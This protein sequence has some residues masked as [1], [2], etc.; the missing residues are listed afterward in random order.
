MCRGAVAVAVAVACLRLRPGRP[1]SSVASLLAGAL[2]TW[3]RLRP[4]ISPF[5]FAG[6]AALDQAQLPRRSPR[7]PC[8]DLERST[9]SPRWT[10]HAASPRA[11]STLALASG[12]VI[13]R[14]PSAV[15]MHRK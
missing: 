13:D 1:A 12:L 9:S 8:L 2:D 3:T 6:M 11:C 10:L 4:P 7:L 5:F 15:S 14:V